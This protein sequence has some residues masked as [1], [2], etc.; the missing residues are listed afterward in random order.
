MKETKINVEEMLERIKEGKKVVD[1]PSIFEMYE[2]LRELSKFRLSDT[3]FKIVREAE[4]KNG[5]SKQ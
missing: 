2:Q 5:N 4:D 3:L 1:M